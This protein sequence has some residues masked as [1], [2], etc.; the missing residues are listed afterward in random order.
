MTRKKAEKIKKAQATIAFMQERLSNLSV[1]CLHNLNPRNE[2][3]LRRYAVGYHLAR[4][5]ALWVEQNPKAKSWPQGWMQEK[6][7]PAHQAL[8]RALKA[9]HETRAKYPEILDTKVKQ[10]SLSL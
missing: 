10:L 9:L 1:D 3:R 7:L 6:C 2:L 8:K 4:I 5:R